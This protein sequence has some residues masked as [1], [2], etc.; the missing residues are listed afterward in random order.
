MREPI[1]DR[2]RIEHMLEMAQ[3]LQ[4]AKSRHT[5]NDIESDRILFYGLTKM[6]EIIGEAAYKLTHEFR[7][8][9]PELPWREII[10]MRHLL[11]HGYFNISVEVL[12]DVILNDIPMMIPI[13][14]MYLREFDTG[15]Q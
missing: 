15:N 6:T 1:K 3:N 12:W 13:L 11:V 10:G 9:H 14:E 4:D 5:I 8:E 7:E 2:G